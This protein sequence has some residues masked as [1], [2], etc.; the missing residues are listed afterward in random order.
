MKARA[1]IAFAARLLAGWTLTV[2][3]FIKLRA[4]AEEFAAALAAY[5]FFPEGLLLPAARVLPWVEYLVGLYLIAGLWLKWTAPLALLLYGGFVTALGAALARGVPLANCGCFGGWSPPPAVTLALDSF[6]V[7]LLAAACGEREN[8]FSLDRR[9]RFHPG[10]KAAAAKPA[11][12]PSKKA[13]R[14]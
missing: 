6:M 13:P 11:P 9:E 2:A 4:P 12:P 10:E 1:W 8:L 3:G 5:R 7:L 14:A